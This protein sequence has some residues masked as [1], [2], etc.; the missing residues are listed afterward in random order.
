MNDLMWLAVQELGDFSKQIG[1]FHITSVL[2]MQSVFVLRR[3]I[4]ITSIL[5]IM[6]Q[7]QDVAGRLI[8][9]L[10]MQAR[11]SPRM[12]YVYINGKSV[13]QF[14]TCQEAMAY[15]RSLDQ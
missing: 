7:L 8:V 6:I 3:T 15:A 12:Y 9:I 2:F 14:R 11:H 13:A 4:S 10:P 1:L 5:Y